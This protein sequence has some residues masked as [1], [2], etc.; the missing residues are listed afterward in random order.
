MS[1]NKKSLA[2][3]IAALI[4]YSAV[5]FIGALYHEYWFDEAQ[6]WV[7]ARDCDIPGILAIMRQ[8][9]HPPLWHLILHIFASMGLP[10]F[11]LGVISWAVSVV[12]A[13]IVI[14]RMP[15]KPYLKAAMLM[16][17]GMI[18][19]NS[20]VSRSYCLINLILVITAI[21][22]PERK[23]RP[24]LF[25]LLVALLANTHVMMCGLVGIYGI[26]MLYDLFSGWK[27]STKKQ[28][29]LSIAGLGIA[30]LG[31]IA[32]VLP[33]LGSMSSNAFAA[34]TE[35]TVSGVVYSLAYS[36]SDICGSAAGQV[37]PFAVRTV[38]AALLQIF[39]VVLIVFC[40]GKKRTF[41]AML[42]F[43]ALFIVVTEV[44][45]YSSPNR[46]AVYVFT[47]AAIYVSGRDEKEK[48]PKSRDTRSAFIKKLS[49]YDEKIRGALPAVMS[50][51]LFVTTPVGVYYYVRDISEDF[52]PSAKTAAFINEN[53]S[54][55]ALLVTDDDTYSDIAAYLP[56][57]KLYSI[58]NASFYTYGRHEI[59]TEHNNDAVARVLRGYDEIYLISYDNNTG[60]VV[61]K[62]PECINF[63]RGSF[64]YS[65]SRLDENDVHV[66]IGQ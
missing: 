37:L 47:L 39:V 5:I 7:I 1:E 12:T 18:Y 9:G 36:L 4:L 29:T 11:A 57:R 49:V 43:S 21:I 59:I 8:E 44:I 55:T 22:F 60:D 62:S 51:A 46:G 19:I 33:L 42:V 14:F 52:Y 54:E 32:L 53:I 45:W 15:A 27:S 48:P 28:N 16:S 34:G 20:V 17:G 35:Y 31:V 56:G 58:A 2:I 66:I 65:I 61:Y 40:H 63:Y 26:Y 30:G 25:G 50:A 3:K 6:A 41:G 24:V 13:A 38:L 10:V 23:S 64:S